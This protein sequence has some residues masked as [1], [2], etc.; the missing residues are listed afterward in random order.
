LSHKLKNI[1]SNSKCPSTD[2]FYNYIE[3]KLEKEEKYLFESHLSSCKFCQEALEG[4]QNTGKVYFGTLLN[5]INSEI[6]SKVKAKAIFQYLSG[7]A[8]ILIVLFIGSIYFLKDTTQQDHLSVRNFAEDELNKDDLEPLQIEKE[9]VQ[10][11]EEKKERKNDIPIAQLENAEKDEFKKDDDLEFKNEVNFSDVNEDLQE[12]E[13]V[14][15]EEEELSIPIAN[16]MVDK[17]N[18]IEETPVT[19]SEG[20]NLNYNDIYKDAVLIK[21]IDFNRLLAFTDEN[22]T[23]K[24]ANKLNMKRKKENSFGVENNSERDDEISSTLEKIVNDLKRESNQNILNNILLQQQ[25]KSWTKDE[26]ATLK[27][28]E[29]IALLKMNKSAQQPLKELKKKK[30]YYQK[31]A[32]KLYKKLY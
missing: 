12:E 23:S 21:E 1:L 25:K 2:D 3:D 13:I 11:E 29:V 26:V 7:A 9:V 22:T 18:T 10:V 32:E 15:S 31:E 28:L 4:F 14:E 5:E 20:K 17:L 16:Q 19:T 8:A 30:N 24:T 6:D 27:W